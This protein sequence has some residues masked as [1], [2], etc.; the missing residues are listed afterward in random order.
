MVNLQRID[1]KSILLKPDDILCF[2]VI[3]N[4]TLRLPFFLKYYREKGICHFFIV[5]NDSDDETLSYLLEQTDTYVWHTQDSFKNKLAWLE[6]LLKDY[7]SNYWCLLVDAD[8][9]FYYPDCETKPIKALCRQI[10][11]QKKDALSIVMLDMYSDKPIQEVQY[12]PGTNFLEV[13]PYFDREFYHHKE[14]LIHDYYWGGLRQRVFGSQTD[15]P[16][17]LYCLT[18]FP[19]IKYHSRMQLYSEHRIKNIK[20]SSTTGC[21]LHFKYPSSF[22]NYVKKEIHRNQH[23]QGAVEYKKYAQLLEK[24]ENLNLYHENLSVKLETSQ[25]LIAMG[26]MKRG[27]QSFLFEVGY[28]VYVRLRAL[29][30]ALSK[31]LWNS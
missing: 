15:N 23:W 1:N 29:G 25:Q 5:D 20:C 30:K 27:Y 24:N 10:E 11:V 26:I 8:E 21:L 9:I 2:A 17:K 14:G 6:W 13:C 28:D 22:V 16:K 12:E 31:K 18:K 3:R 19:L 7:G 4:E